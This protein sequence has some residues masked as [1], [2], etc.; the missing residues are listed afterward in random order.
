MAL[1][2]FRD[3]ETETGEGKPKVTQL[4][5]ESIPGALNQYTTLPAWGFSAISTT[6]S[7]ESEL[8]GAPA[9]MKGPPDGVGQMASVTRRS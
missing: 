3:E 4:A 1:T 6:W 7:L 9:C 8:L 5:A 2:T